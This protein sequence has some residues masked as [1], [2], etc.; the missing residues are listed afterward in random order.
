MAD[1]NNDTH[2][3]IKRKYIK[4]AL[5]E[6]ELDTFNVLLMKI[7]KIAPDNKYIVV[8]E[9]EFYAKDVLDYIIKQENEVDE[10]IKG[11]IELDKDG[12]ITEMLNTDN[13]RTITKMLIGFFD[14]NL[15]GRNYG[16]FKE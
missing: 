16:F 9:D 14:R 15:K 10:I 5:T 1:K 8:N 12:Q 7:D 3:V 13:G 6:N 2:L 11:C 4:Q